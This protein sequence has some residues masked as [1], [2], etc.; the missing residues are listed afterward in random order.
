MDLTRGRALAAPS[1]APLW[2]AASPTGA[3]ESDCQL[4]FEAIPSEDA[5]PITAN[6][7]DPIGESRLMGRTLNPGG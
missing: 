4:V 7:G 5:G 3:A 1:L 2:L 6:L